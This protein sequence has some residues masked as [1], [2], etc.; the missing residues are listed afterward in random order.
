MIGMGRPEATPGQSKAKS[1]V[2]LAKKT[3]MDWEG[4]KPCPCPI[5]IGKR[6]M[7][8]DPSGNRLLI[9]VN[10][11]KL[12]PLLV[13]NGDGLVGPLGLRLAVNLRI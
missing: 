9:N 1:S 10:V 3:E 6:A 5:T 4:P 12:R 2:L 7:L 8:A 11:N 13:I